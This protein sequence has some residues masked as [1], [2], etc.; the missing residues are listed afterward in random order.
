[1]LTQCDLDLI[2]INA[3]HGRDGVNGAPVVLS[4]NVNL[5]HD[6]MLSCPAGDPR[7]PIRRLGESC[8]TS[9]Y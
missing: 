8:Q 1:M 5:S 6:V 3:S 2:R 9:S 4:R 7:N